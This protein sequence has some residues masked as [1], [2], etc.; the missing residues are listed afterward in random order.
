MIKYHIKSTLEEKRVYL[1]LVFQMDRVH[2]GRK[3]IETGKHDK[4][5]E[6]ANHIFVH[7]GKKK[8]RK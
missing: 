7:I 2:H 1:S 8:N 3:S 4:N 5:K 6:P